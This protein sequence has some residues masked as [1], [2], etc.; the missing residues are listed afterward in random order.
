M[1][2]NSSGAYT[3]P[4]GNPVVTGTTITSTWANSTLTDVASEITNSLDRSGRGAMLAALKIVDGSTS[5]PG[6]VFNTET[7]SGL[8]RSAAGQ[9]SL[10]VLATEVLR[11]TSSGVTALV[12][13]TASSTSLT[14][15]TNLTVNGNT[16]LGD[17][18]GDTLTVASSA[19]TWSGNPAHSGNH[20]FN[21]NLVVNGG[22]QLGDA[23]GDAL[24][25]NSSSVS[26]P[27][28]PAHSGNHTFNGNVGIG[29][30]PSS[31][32]G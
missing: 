17:A 1:P 32:A 12:P 10:S 31:F 25:V 18:A 7:T 5:A 20:T 8:S 24:T 27:N 16:T 4:A 14:V 26:W 2:R 28:N 22:T 3:L 30:A 15:G 19:V 23:S 29:T 9:L 21:G 6:L 13:F 11:L